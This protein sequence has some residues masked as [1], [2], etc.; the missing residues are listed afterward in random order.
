MSVPYI[1]LDLGYLCYRAFYST[2]HLS[3]EETKTGVLFGVFRDIKTFSELFGSNRFI[4]CF[5]SRESKR[6]AIFPGYKASRKNRYDEM[7]EDE[8]LAHEELRKQRDFLETRYLPR[9]GYKNILSQ[10]GYEA[11]DLIA[12]FCNGLDSDEEAVVVGTDGDLYQIL[13]EGVTIWNPAKSKAITAESFTG[14]WGISPSQWA[15]VK[16]LA[17]CHTDDVPGLDGV[18]EKTAVKFLTGTLKPGGVAY[19]KITAANDLWKRNLEL[20]RLPLPG[21]VRPEVLQDEVTVEKWQYV[22]D[23]LGMSSLREL[24]MPF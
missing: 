3:F 6:K 5:D 10:P 20:V 14:E 11:D 17:G 9:I 8:R 7:E 1:V 22:M 19:S 24:A 16:A 2:G 12:A 13:R 15:D 23:R 18:G 21:C 4:F